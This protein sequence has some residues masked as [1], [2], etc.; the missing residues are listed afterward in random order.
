MKPILKEWVE[1]IGRCGSLEM[2]CLESHGGFMTPAAFS[3][4]NTPILSDVAI[5]SWFL[6]SSMHPWDDRQR[7]V[8]TFI[9]HF[10]RLQPQNVDTAETLMQL[11][12]H[13]KVKGCPFDVCI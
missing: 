10:R 5:L 4:I 9:L 11:A 13:Q 6:P 8:R 12:Q 2:L 7:V 3:K 1:E